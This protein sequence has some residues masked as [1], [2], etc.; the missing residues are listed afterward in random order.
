[1]VV[2]RQKD[3]MQ[4]QL[5]VAVAQI[6]SGGMINQNLV[7]IERQVRAAAAVGA[8]L[9]LFSECALQGYG[10]ESD[11]SA[12]VVAAQA[13]S[14]DS[15]PCRRISA[16]A[17]SLGLVVMV[18]FFE[19]DG[20]AFYNSCLVAWPDGRLETERKH[21]LTPPELAAGLTSG[22][23]ARRSFV[24]NGVKCAVVICADG[25]IDGLYPMLRDEGFDYRLC[26]TAG[27]GA[28]ADML[29]ESDLDGP[30]GRAKY[31]EQRARVFN[32][33]AI[34]DLT[35]NHGLG[36]ASANA[37]GPVGARTCHMGHCM[38]VDSRGVMRAQIPGTPVLEHQQD[39]MT[40]AE[41]LF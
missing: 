32:T 21:A 25:G 15:A 11:L 26:P 31:E 8:D 3:R 23:R 2:I 12:A 16:L 18:G 14:V 38:I 22:V 39:R 37:L 17:Q 41:I 13:V 27:G 36:F 35:E 24:I 1:M 34:H 28:L 20:S 40:H 10:Y 19:A 33:E 5:H 4:R 30:A 7:R 9:I 6:H 29:H